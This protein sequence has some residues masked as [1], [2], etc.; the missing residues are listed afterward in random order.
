[1][2]TYEESLAITTELLRPYVAKP[3]AIRPQDHI[4]ADLGLDSIAVMEFAADL[5]ARCKVDIPPSEYQK[6]FTVE[7]VARSIARLKAE[8]QSA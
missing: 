3:D 5:E 2:T 4:Q 1:M 7:D 8:R 6:L